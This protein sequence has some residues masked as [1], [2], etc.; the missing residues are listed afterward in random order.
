LSGLLVPAQGRIPGLLAALE[1]AD[2]ELA[3]VL[4]PVLVK[5]PYAD[6]ASALLQVLQLANAAARKAAASALA[7]LD[8]PEATAALRRAA[9]QEP[10][11]GVREICTL[12]L[13]Q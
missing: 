13:A 2:D 1:M 5:L 6:A 12:L 11:P 7:A 4:T 10:D 8:R 9:D 3:P